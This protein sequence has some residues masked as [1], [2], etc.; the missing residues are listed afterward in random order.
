ME[1]NLLR[2]EYDLLVIGG[3]AGSL[4]VIISILEQLLTARYAVVIVLH[5]RG[6]ADSLLAGLLASRTAMPV[7]EAEEKELIMPGTVYLAP[8]DYH[9]LIERDHTFSLDASEKVHFSRPSIDVTFESAAII[10]RHKAAGL[11]LSGGNQDG[12][13]GLQSISKTGGLTIVQ[14]PGSAEVGMMPEFAISLFR[15]DKIITKEEL[16]EYIRH[17]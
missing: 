7:K 5:R 4:S 8:A 2:G 17:L 14:D 1:E 9:L 6:S 15:P 12:S 16:P 3:S 11:L 13:A 10:Y